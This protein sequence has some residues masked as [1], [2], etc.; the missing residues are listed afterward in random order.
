MNEKSAVLKREKWVDHRVGNH[1]HLEQAGTAQF[2]YQVCN[3]IK[4]PILFC[5]ISYSEIVDELL[6]KHDPEAW[7]DCI[8]PVISGACEFTT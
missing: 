2:G 6:P 4:N 1:H 7:E 5:I 3:P 8:G